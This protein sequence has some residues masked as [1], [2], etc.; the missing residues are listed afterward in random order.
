MRSHLSLEPNRKE[1]CQQLFLENKKCYRNNTI[2]HSIADFQRCQA[3]LVPACQ[4]LLPSSGDKVYA[5]HLGCPI[6]KQNLAWHHNATLPFH[7]V[8]EDIIVDCVAKFFAAFTPDTL[9]LQQNRHR[10]PPHQLRLRR[11][12]H[13][14]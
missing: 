3:L 5:K 11:R 10:Q 6:V 8:K 14:F 12:R 9:N 1:Q 7:Y 2:N 4:D 13:L